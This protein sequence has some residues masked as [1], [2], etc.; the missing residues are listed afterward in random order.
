MD[1]PKI[2][3]EER[4]QLLNIRALS[5]PGGEPVN[6]KGVPKIVYPWLVAP[7]VGSADADLS[8]QC[9]IAV[10]ERMRQRNYRLTAAGTIV[11]RAAQAVG[12][13]SATR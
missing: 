1:M 3:G 2:Y 6:G 4:K 12:V 7:T 8:A 5:I 13:S 10:V 9:P 11:F